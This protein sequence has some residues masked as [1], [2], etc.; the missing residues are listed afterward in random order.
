MSKLCVLGSNTVNIDA[1]KV[2]D[3]YIGAEVES[4]G[5]QLFCLLNCM[6]Y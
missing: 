5:Q 6:G 1:V 3:S 2:A 4:T